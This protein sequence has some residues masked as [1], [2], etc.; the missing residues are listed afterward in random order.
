[1]F[2][3]NVAAYQMYNKPVISLAALCDDRPDWRPSEFRYGMWGCQ[4]AM[5]FRAAKLLDFAHDVEALERD[6]NPFSVVVLTNVKA[7][8]T[9]NDAER[10]KIWKLR[11]IK[12]LY[13]RNWSKERIIEFLVFID[14]MLQL[15]TELEKQLEREVTEFE[16]ETQMKKYVSSFERFATERGKKVG[17]KKGQET[18]LL[19]SISVLLDAKFGRK[20]AE[21]L[22]KVRL[23]NGITELR[24]F[25]RFLSSADSL[26]EVRK[27]LD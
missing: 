21:M 11:I 17:F 6:E 14:F 16:E 20:G 24:S 9:R 25:F 18:E 26:E 7:N 19:E 2:H 10:R 4:T 5:A 8:E 23:L 13:R 1:M 3:Y 12:G 15:P 22:P 27:R